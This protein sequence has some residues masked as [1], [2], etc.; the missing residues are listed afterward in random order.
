MKRTF[1]I[2]LL[3]FSLSAI[4]END[5][6]LIDSLQLKL[7][8]SSGRVWVST[9]IALSEELVFDDPE[10]SESLLVEAIKNS[11][12]NNY[13]L[14]LAKAYQ[15]KGFR[16]Y[17][18]NKVLTGITYFQKS[19]STYSKFNYDTE[20]IQSLIGIANGLSRIRKNKE[21]ID[22]LNYVLKQFKDSISFQKK[23]DVYHLISTNYYD[24][25]ENEKAIQYIDS[26][27]V[28]ENSNNLFA[29]LADS[30]NSLGIIYLGI[31]EN[32]NALYYYDKCEEL[33]KEIQDTVL[34]SYSIYNKALIYY[35]WG[36][37]DEALSLLFKAKDLDKMLGHDEELPSSFSSIALVYHDI[38][39]YNKA[40]Y[41]Y[42]ESIRLAEKY[43]DQETKS[44]TLHNLGELLAS[45]GKYD[46]ALILINQS[47]K[48]EMENLNTLGIAQSKSTIADIYIAL[49]KYPLAFEYFHE[50][51]DV[52][53][54]FGSK[55]D[56]AELYISMSKGHNQLNNDSLSIYYIKKGIEI[57]EQ[58][59]AR[60][61]SLEANKLA[62]EYFEKM[63]VYDQSLDHYKRYKSLNDSIF[64]ENTSKR[65]D[66][67]DLRIEKQEQEKQLEKLENEKKLLEADR[68]TRN[69]QL[70]AA[71]AFSVLILI[72]FGIMYIVIKRS[73]KRIKQ[74]YHV[75]LE[76]EQ[77]IKALLDASFDSIL[78]VDKD[79]IVRAANSNNLS[80]F[81]PSV[82]VLINQPILNLFEETNQKVL[83]KYIELVY[84]SKQFKELRIHDKNNIIL[85]LKISPVQDAIGNVVS[86]AFY[87]Q[88]I[89]QTESDKLEKKKI[90]EQLI[91][92]QKMETI[93]TLAGGIAHDF[94]NYLATIKGYVSMSI[95]DAD[96]NSTI[97]N[98]LT[99]TLKAVNLSQE[100]IKKLLTFSRSKE[101]NFQKFSLNELVK[102]SI[103][104]VKGSKPRNIE[105]K[106]NFTASNIQL[107]GEKNQLTQVLLNICT[108]A[109]H[110]I[111]AEKGGKVE[112]Y[113]EE[114]YKIKDLND[115]LCTCIKV[116]DNGIGMKKETMERIFEPF[117]TT[118]EV[119]KGTG[120]GLSVVTGIIK[121]HG[122]KIEVYSE[123]GNGSE[124]SLYLPIIS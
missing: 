45:I 34:I 50:A 22:T 76:S 108:N 47:M 51:E 122:G 107:L 101:M 8:R 56:L 119:G 85:N 54:K 102:D 64:N 106:Y 2:I 39:N 111:E 37:Y 18:E 81:L 110:A 38:K 89:T 25:G 49:E 55:I 86:L 109:F 62:S 30:Y 17:D 53:K 9:A 40:K 52:F 114:P 66:Y 3:L 26:A 80:G 71:I 43:D 112:L 61:I 57:A 58:I 27:I 91:H 59:N 63:N 24:Q 46:T 12:E 11:I 94:N 115:K 121:Q 21:S 77:K 28:I 13:T 93:G 33:A 70:T 84:S 14:L 6:D 90:E 82:E 48:F 116:L 69:I 29:Q 123:F 44:I 72:F 16:A 95:E 124:F 118:K 96:K 65:I 23:A 99:K 4:A 68:E 60:S 1:C 35:T 97:H 67:L 42:L 5:I 92:T 117:Y 36:V 88:D 19:L 41:Y 75:L 73:E 32:K 83:R 79:G 78:L 15:V 105:F 100:T 103:D 31:G 87:I 7:E 98:Y 113:I 120:L 104:I 10:Y 20:S 74:Q